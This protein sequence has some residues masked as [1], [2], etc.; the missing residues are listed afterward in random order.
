MFR[1]IALLAA[2]AAAAS[3]AQVTASCGDLEPGLREVKL[4][5]WPSYYR[6]QDAKGLAEFLMEDFRLVGADGSVGQ[7]AEELAWVEKNAWNP[8]DFLYTIRSV[9]CPAP[10]VAIIIGE[11]RFKS[12]DKDKRAWQ[13]HRY[14]S[15]NV[16]V[17]VRGKWRAASS[18]LSGETTKPVPD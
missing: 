3:P 5:Q 2:L 14:V 7:R 10:G 18:H 11:G 6:N 4:K 15:S 8:T 1:P 16:L 13:E 17:Q 12:Q 9:H